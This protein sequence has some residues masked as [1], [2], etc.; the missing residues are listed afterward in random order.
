MT[1]YVA[2][3]MIEARGRKW[4][5]EI[6]PEDE[7]RR[8]EIANRAWDKRQKLIPSGVYAQRGVI[9]LEEIAA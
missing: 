9:C 5:V 7:Y 6:A 4:I 2:G 3:Q 8:I 1:T